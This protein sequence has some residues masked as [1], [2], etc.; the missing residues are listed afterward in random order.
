MQI[1][2][3]PNLTLR[4]I[5]SR[6]ASALKSILGDAEVMRYSIVGVHDDRQIKQFIEQRLLSYLECGFGLYALV[7]KQSQEMI[8][9]CGFFIQSIAQQQEVEVGYRLARQ[10]WGRGLGTEAAR[11][12]VQYG[13]ER[14]NFQRFVCLIEP[15]NIR[16]VRV[17]T[18][19]GMSLEKRII[20]HGLDVAMYSMNCK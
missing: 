18:K 13:R 19:L 14:Y 17:A 2:E 3:T 11:A 16:S 20:Y 5:T 7:H 9:Y 8:G 10:Y 4:Y 12:V 6:D 15:E 1:I